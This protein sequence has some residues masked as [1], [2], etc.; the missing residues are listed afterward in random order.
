LLFGTGGVGDAGVV[1][2]GD[3]EVTGGVGMAGDV[4]VVGWVAL[5]GDV[6]VTGGV[7]G[8]T[9]GVVVAGAV[10]EESVDWPGALLADDPVDSVD[11]VV[12]APPSPPQAVKTIAHAAATI[13]R[14]GRG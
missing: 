6:E 11:S 14:T 12:V 7:A 8:G 13:I 5:V 2:V 4:E 10:G 9:V 1:G 3:V